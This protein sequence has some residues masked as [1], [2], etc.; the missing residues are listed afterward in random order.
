MGEIPGRWVEP[1]EA[2]ELLDTW[3][4]VDG[5]CATPRGLEDLEPSFVDARGTNPESSCGDDV[6]ATALAINGFLF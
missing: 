6:S 4:P 2:W 1:C 3:E 5:E